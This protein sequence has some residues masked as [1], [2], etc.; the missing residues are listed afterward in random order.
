MKIQ[1]NPIK[2]DFLE[3]TT[4][5]LL[6]PIAVSRFNA[7]IDQLHPML[8]FVKNF[9]L[10]EN[11]D[12]DKIYDILI[13]VE[14]A[15]VN[16]IQYGFPQKERG[17]IEITCQKDQNKMLILDIK[18]SGIP[19]DPLLRI[20][21]YKKSGQPFKKDLEPGGSGIFL[22]GTLIDIIEYQRKDETNHLHFVKY[23][24]IVG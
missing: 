20:N 12:S 16:I 17:S 22:Y 9:C 3:G 6:L 18:D 4:S 7:H 23:L 13:S 10:Q 5:L 24:K 8:T 2:G 21:E 15:V 14:E 19:F 11:I 1:L